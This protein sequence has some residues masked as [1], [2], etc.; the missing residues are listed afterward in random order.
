[1][2]SIEH[3]S[4]ST[5][6]TSLRDKNGAHV[7]ESGEIYFEFC[8]S[9]PTSVPDDVKYIDRLVKGCELIKVR[10]KYRTYRRVFKLDSDHN[11]IQY[12]STK[13]CLRCR[14]NASNKSESER[15]DASPPQIYI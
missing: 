15:N 3:S 7:L 10:P 9:F 1:M 11:A 2:Q 5:A 8:R 14:A 6:L 12:Q 13:S 4:L